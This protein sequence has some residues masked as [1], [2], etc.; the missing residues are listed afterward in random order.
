[1]N[2]QKDDLAEVTS[3]D[4]TT[5]TLKSNQKMNVQRDDTDEVT[6]DD[7]TTATPKSNQ[8]M[9]VQQDNTDEVTPDDHTTV[10]VD[11]NEAT[12]KSNQKKNVQRDDTDEATTN[13]HTTVNIGTNEATLKT[14]QKTNVQRDDTVKVTSDDH[15]TATLKSNQKKNVQRND[16]DEATTNYHTTVNIGTNE[17]TLKTSKKLSLHKDD[18]VE[19][20]TN[21]HT[22]VNIYT[23][24]A[25]L[26]SNQTTNVQRDDTDEVTSDDYTTATLKSNQKMNVQR[27][28]T[29]EVTSD[30]YTTATLKSNQKMN[31]QRDDTEKVTSDDYTTATL[32]SN[33]KKNVQRDDTDEVTSDDHTTVNVDTNEATLKSNQK[34]N[35]QRDDTDEVT[36]DDHTTATLKSNQKMNVQRDDTDEVTSDD[37]TTATLK[38]NQKKNVQ[39][40]DTDEVSYTNST[41]EDRSTNNMIAYAEFNQMLCDISDQIDDET[42]KTLKERCGDNIPAAMK[43]EAKNAYDIFILLYKHGHIGLEKTKYL[44][45]LLN[46]I[47][48]A[49]LSDFVKKVQKGS[50]IDQ[51]DIYPEYMEASDKFN[52]L[53]CDISDEINDEKLQ[54]LKSRCETIIPEGKRAKLKRVYDVFMEL[55]LRK[56][57]THSNTRYLEKCLT[58]I[59]EGRMLEKVHMYHRMIKGIP[60]SSD[61]IISGY[62]EAYPQFDEMIWTISTEINKETET[63]TSLK[64]W[65]SEKITESVFKKQNAYDVLKELYLRRDITLSNT[66][67]LEKFLANN[68]KKELL[69]KCAE[70]HKTV[71]SKT[72]KPEGPLVVS[73]VS[74]HSC[75][76]KWDHPKDGGTKKQ[77]Y[78]IEQS[79]SKTKEWTASDHISTVDSCYVET[80]NPATTY[81]FRICGVNSFGIKSDY[82][83][84]NAIKTKKTPTYKDDLKKIAEQ[85]QKFNNEKE[86]ISK[87]LKKTLSH[88]EELK[89]KL[90]RT[91][92]KLQS[93]NNEKDHISKI[94]NEPIEKHDVHMQ[95]LSVQRFTAELKETQ[96]TYEKDVQIQSLNSEK[97]RISAELKETQNKYKQLEDEIKKKDKQI[98]SLTNEKDHTIAKMKVTQLDENLKKIN[99]EINQINAGFKETQSKYKDLEENLKMKDEEI[100]KLSNDNSRIS[101][102]LKDTQFKYCDLQNKVKKTEETLQSK[103]IEMNG[104]SEK[105]SKYNYLEEH[106]KMNDENIHSL[107]KEKELISAELKE[108]QSKYKDLEE[109]IKMNDENIHSLNKEKELISA[110]L[111]E[112]QSKYKNL[113]EHIKMN[114]E[115]I[116][117]L[118]KEKELISA[119]LKETQSKYNDLEEHIKMNDENIH[120]L[121]KEKEL[122]SAELKETQS[123]YNDLEEHIKMN[124]ENIHSLNK[125]KE[126]ISAELKETQSKYKDLEENLKMKDEEVQKLSNANYRI[127]AEL[128]DAQLKYSDLENK[129]KK[130]DETLQSKMIEMDGISEK[131]SKY[132]DLENHIML[133]KENIHS[134][135][136][137]KELISAELKETQSKSKEFQPKQNKTHLHYAAEKGDSK[138]VGALLL[139]GAKVNA[140]DENHDT[141]LHNATKNGHTSIVDLLLIKGADVKAVN[142][143]KKTPLMLALGEKKYDVVQML[144]VP[145][146]REMNNVDDE[147]LEEVLGK[148]QKIVK[149]IT[150][151]IYEKDGVDKGTIDLYEEDAKDKLDRIYNEGYSVSVVISCNDDA[152]QQLNTLFKSRVIHSLSLYNVNMTNIGQLKVSYSLYMYKIKSFDAEMVMSWILPTV[153]HF[154]CMKIAMPAPWYIEF[155]GTLNTL[156]ICDS[157][158][159]SKA[160][161]TD[162]YIHIQ[163][164]GL[165]SLY[166]YNNGLTHI[167]EDIGLIQ[168]LSVFDIHGNS[169]QRLPPSLI[170]NQYTHFNVDGS[171]VSNVPVDIVETGTKAIL[172]YLKRFLDVNTVPNKHVKAVIVGHEGAGKTTLVKALGGK[173]D[174][175]TKTD[176]IEISQLV[177]KKD[178]IKLNVFDF[179]GDVDFLESHSLFM[180]DDT[181]FILVFDLSKFGLGIDDNASIHQLG[182]VVLWL[183]NIFAQASQS[184]CILVGT[185]VDAVKN[186]NE[187]LMFIWGKFVSLLYSAMAHHQ[188]LIEGNLVSNCLI[189][190]PLTTPLIKQ[191]KSDRGGVAGY[192]EVC[193]VPS[194]E[195]VKSESYLCL[196]HI[197]GYC[198]VGSV[199]I[200]KTNRSVDQVKMIIRKVAKEMLEVLPHIPERWHVF[201]LILK[202]QRSTPVLMFEKY[203]QL[204]SEIGIVSDKVL[205][206]V[207]SF[208]RSQGDI[209]YRGMTGSGNIVILDPQWLAN[210]LKTLVS[211]NSWWIDKNGILQKQCLESAWQHIDTKYHSH[212]LS[213]FIDIG[214]CFP[215]KLEKS[216]P[217]DVDLLL[218]PCKLP[219]GQPEIDDWYP[220]VK[221]GDLQ[222]SYIYK[223]NVLPEVLFYDVVVQVL[224]FDDLLHQLKIFRNNLVYTVQ[225]GS[226]QCD[227]CKEVNPQNSQVSIYK[228]RFELLYHTNS[229]VVTVRGKQPCCVLQDLDKVMVS[230]YDSPPFVGV[231][232]VRLTTCPVCICNRTPC[233]GHMR[234]VNSSFKCTEY[235][236]H[237]FHSWED[238]LQCKGMELTSSLP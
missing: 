158:F 145:S 139:E 90:E 205:M 91:Q 100:Q 10:N 114:D 154:I 115:N 36:P 174:K 193:K 22:T 112:T 98:L 217:Q 133:N 119:E 121:N 201:R 73:D 231:S 58:E 74:E 110:E 168:G 107:N 157:Q 92:I 138:S 21:Y 42:L 198:E 235:H 81:Y 5:A 16:T 152:I 40:D 153:K 83:L 117:S 194:V 124:D 230:V 224:K 87:S 171:M 51:S 163:C 82:L 49:K 72:Y 209:V 29:D 23:N 183:K 120:S 6:S 37:H 101:A 9:N 134:L 104:I 85:I 106:I 182:R 199:G 162:R 191:R 219:V 102:E 180:T 170:K 202:C 195:A 47:G 65:F 206:N 169:I 60:E 66:S 141:P 67:D 137:E 43:K 86:C 236:E 89:E 211:F 127:S 232:V 132:N 13:Y 185:H 229:I 200:L 70:Y 44:E 222:A 59:K 88:Y 55:C 17:A 167:Q 126:L 184:R 97:D 103:M 131:Q 27:D 53:L 159:P 148:T 150:V 196:P 24:E 216:G 228:V 41:F 237:V 113:E 45:S 186:T 108:T 125:E 28:D 15:T 38:S 14:Y 71:K 172:S 151:A 99:K 214:I 48:R 8:K 146:L 31:V 57:I 62:E 12:L 207:T 218:F 177:F 80:L 77:K 35:V 69:Q 143:N 3:D 95:S 190:Q 178:N 26:K 173:V 189:C 181:L 130:N 136:K 212:L 61:N 54:N 11:T 225:T 164:H 116:H 123:K 63:L 210:Q 187:F 32:K 129:V 7:Y 192:V 93:L 118:N 233:V 160:K 34:K 144:L 227:R 166:M 208:L 111:K 105:Q 4:H 52:R 46:D 25:T 220:K 165:A 20:T 215:C 175:V 226:T 50:F 76:L 197:V 147:Q 234:R 221:E 30:D 75:R 56:Q 135:N 161:S 68:E 64:D 142:K 213:L 39:R 2:M 179:A 109:H 128:R 204:A 155:G 18:T 1:M 19:V 96:C 122:I 79:E 149:S 188:K 156:K 238:M 203:K 84:S 94:L 78:V 176:G 223:F 140:V 33:Q